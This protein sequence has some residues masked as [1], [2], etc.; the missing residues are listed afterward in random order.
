MLEYAEAYEDQCDML[1]IAA[2]VP[3]L[4]LWFQ[5]LAEKG[6]DWQAQAADGRA[7]T[8]VT[9]HRGKGLEWPVVISM[10]LDSKVKNR[11]WG[12]TVLQREDGFDMNEPLAGRRLRYWPKPFGGH[13]TGIRVLDRIAES[14]VGLAA[15]SSATDE[16]R[17]LLY[18]STTRA[19]DH[20]II[21][22]HA[23]KP[24]GEW[25]ESLGADWL[26]PKGEELTLPDGSTIPTDFQILEA[27]DGWARESED[28]SARWVASGEKHEGL[29]NRNLSPSSA[30]A[31]V[32]SVAG[33]VVELGER[34]VLDNVKD[35]TALGQAIHSL[36]GSEINS[37]DDAECSR[38]VRVLRE[39]GFEDSVDPRAAAQAARRFIEWVKS[40]FEPVAWNVEHPITHVLDT[41]QVAQGFIDL[42]LETKDGWVIVDHKATPRPRNEWQDI[43]IGYS[44]QLAMYKSAVEAISGRPVTSTWIH[45]PVGG[46]VLTVSGLK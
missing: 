42:L 18:V 19:R 6:E 14:P 10:D 9:H 33:D 22:L 5:D 28:Y 21:P 45:L 38:A 46:G 40:T 2:T 17:R 4:I 13:T 34:I 20:L 15:Q 16:I 39:W 26:L 29:V 31:I 7:V 35:V 12:L 1:N 37:P 43:A 3:G 36:I 44:G 24:F 32:T 27:P 8:L 11:L 23:K 30:D 25:L 41:G